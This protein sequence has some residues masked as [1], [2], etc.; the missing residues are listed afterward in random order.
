MLKPEL[1]IYGEN[2]TQYY[3]Y[4]KS[5]V[6][7]ET[8]QI[9]RNKTEKHWWGSYDD[10]E[11]FFI[12]PL[13]S[14][15]DPSELLLNVCDWYNSGKQKPKYRSDEEL[16]VEVKNISKALY[17]IENLFGDFPLNSAKR[18]QAYLN[19]P[20][21]ERW[22]DIHSIIIGGGFFTVWQAVIEM[23]P[24]F[25]K[26]GPTTDITGKIVSDWQRIPTP[27]EL[28]RAISNKVEK[29]GIAN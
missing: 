13:H 15:E 8:V 2:E 23:D 22:D 28:Y 16:A 25:P 10:S 7:K 11:S 4:F 26:V 19:E 6:P 3:Y 27:F 18:I 5:D 29:K 21:V 12:I 1:F 9:I 20:T 17:K 14:K 24:T